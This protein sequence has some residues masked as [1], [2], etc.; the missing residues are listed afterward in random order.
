MFSAIVAAQRRRSFLLASS[1][2]V[3]IFS[4]GISAAKAQQSP[5][6]QLPPIVVSPAG[7][8][9][10]TRAKLV[11][12]EG[13][14]SRRVAPKVAP[15]TNTSV[16]PAPGPTVSP[17]SGATTVPQFNGIVGASSAVITA[18]DISRSPAQTLQEIIAQTPGVQ[19]T[20]LFGGV[21]GA[22]TS[23][24]L[25]GFG[26]FS[27]SNTLLL[28]DGRRVNDIDIRPEKQRR[29]PAGCDPR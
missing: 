13:S 27:T 17:T 28:I 25:R 5:P 2:F 23:V 10:R 24:D 4:L 6:D 29:R 21:N 18:E 15:A 14:G 16:A 22:R 1:F 7:H 9:N 8:Q 3:P 12:D 20:S 11:S 19:L 26:A